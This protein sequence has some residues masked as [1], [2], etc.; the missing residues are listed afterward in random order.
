MLVNSVCFVYYFGGCRYR[1][2]TEQ[3]YRKADGVLAMYDV[4]DSASFA[5]VRG[6]V[7]CVKVSRW[8]V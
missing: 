7:D 1:S 8:S 3:Y 2:I 6:W 5:A 4:T